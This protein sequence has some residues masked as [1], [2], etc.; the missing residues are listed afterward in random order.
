MCQAP[1]AGRPAWRPDRPPQIARFDPPPDQGRAARPGLRRLALQ[2]D[3]H[4]VEY[5]SFEGEIA[6]G[7]Y[8]AGTVTIW[9]RGAYDAIEQTEHRIVGMED[10]SEFQITIVQSRSVNR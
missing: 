5:G 3:D 6:P 2:V 7:Q 8:G 10:G 4:P 9:D 1:D